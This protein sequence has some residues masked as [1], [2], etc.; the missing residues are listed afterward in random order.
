MHLRK[1]LAAG[2]AIS[3]LM[4]AGAQAQA[5]QEQDAAKAVAAARG[6]APIL[7]WASKPTKLPAFKAPNKLVYRFADVM[8]AHK[9]KQNWKQE[10]HLTRDFVANWISMAPGKKTKTA[11]HADDKTFWEVQSGQMKVTIEGQEPFIAGK[12]FLVNVPNRLTYQHGNGR[13]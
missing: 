7:A 2:A 10:V 9:G 11:F 5:P 1:S 4:L 12:H 13:H 6:N 3:L 8:A